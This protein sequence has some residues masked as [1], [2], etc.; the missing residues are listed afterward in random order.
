MGFLGIIMPT[1]STA[2]ATVQ[3]ALL[4]A[5]NNPS[6]CLRSRLGNDRCWPLCAVV[7]VGRV[8]YCKDGLPKGVGSVKRG[9]LT[10]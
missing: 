3:R 5:Y 10:R 4:A 8:S 7:F 1:Q 9:S 6:S 2:R